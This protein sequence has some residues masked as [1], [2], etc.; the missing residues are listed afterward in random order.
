MYVY[1]LHTYGS[2]QY[3]AAKLREIHTLAYN[4]EHQGFTF[5]C[6]S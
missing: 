2:F 3:T 5:K 6:K 1:L 4:T